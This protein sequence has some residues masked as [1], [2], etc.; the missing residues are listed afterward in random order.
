MNE[1]KRADAET[2]VKDK[3]KTGDIQVVKIDIA[4]YES[5]VGATKLLVDRTKAL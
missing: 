1:G 4:K 2:Q 3:L 5:V